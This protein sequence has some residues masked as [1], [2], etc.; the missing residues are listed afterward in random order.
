L[1]ENHHGAP[2]RCDRFPALFL[3]I[4]KGE[5]GERGREGERGERSTIDPEQSTINTNS[6]PSPITAP[7]FAI[8]VLIL[9][10][11][12]PHSL[13][14]FSLPFLSSFFHTS[15]GNRSSISSFDRCFIIF[16]QN[17][18]KIIYHFKEKKKGGRK[19]EGGRGGGGGE[20]RGERGEG[21]GEREEGRD[22]LE[23]RGS[24]IWTV[25]SKLAATV[26]S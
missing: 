10:L 22:Y 20:G 24:L 11:T 26:P 21:R 6:C 14:S 17:H 5:E 2:C 16:L 7:P 3:H 8:F 1:Q 19:E 9:P 23:A 13:F 25:S 4:K 15:K 18:P 12:S